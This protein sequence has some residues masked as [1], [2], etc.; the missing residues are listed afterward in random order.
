M[1]EASSTRW[2]ISR[3]RP[4]TYTLYRMP[5]HYGQLNPALTAA[6]RRIAAGNS[7]AVYFGPHAYDRE[8][9]REIDHKDV[10][11]CLKKGST[12]G[13][14]HINGELRANV[15]HLGVHVRVVINGL[16]TVNE[17][18]GELDSIGVVSVIKV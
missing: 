8:G 2:G 15:V 16:D 14:E 4:E 17:N 6:I 3:S 10:W 5:P 7:E 12:Y 18:W 1:S 13:P 11:T 9:E